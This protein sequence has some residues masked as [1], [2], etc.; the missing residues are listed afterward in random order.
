[1]TRHA[2]YHGTLTK[3]VQQGCRC[4][5]CLEAYEADQQT[6]V[7]GLDSPLY[8]RM[9]QI[10]DYLDWAQKGTPEYEQA[11]KDYQVALHALAGLRAAEDVA[12]EQP[13]CW[14]PVTLKPGKS[15]SARG[16]AHAVPRAHTSSGHAA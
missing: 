12:L 1:M 5:R 11:F 3:Y 9:E 15:P 2:T 4:R 16:Y 6:R 10:A 7:G 13:E 8:A 14:R